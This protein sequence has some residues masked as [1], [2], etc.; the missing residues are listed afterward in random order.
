MSEPD[1][2]QPCSCCD[3]VPSHWNI[4]F[5]SGVPKDFA[6]EVA[7]ALFRNTGC[8]LRGHYASSLGVPGNV[9]EQL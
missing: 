2:Q 7:E 4:T 9:V 3:V 1:D 5:G 6:D 8:P